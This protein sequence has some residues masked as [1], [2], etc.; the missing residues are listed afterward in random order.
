MV[1]F[2]IE[3]FW[4]VGLFSE[5]QA[6]RHFESLLVCNGITLLAAVKIVTV[7]DVWPYVPAAAVA[8]PDNAFSRCASRYGL[9]SGGQAFDQCTLL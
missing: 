6:F 1:P 4:G 7:P 5:R 9:N 3:E 8:V 2:T